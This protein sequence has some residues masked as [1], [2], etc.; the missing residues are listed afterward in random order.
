M[1]RLNILF[2]LSKILCNC[3]LILILIEKIYLVGIIFIPSSV[4]SDWMT[5]VSR[6]FLGSCFD[7]VIKQQRTRD[8]ADILSLTNSVRLVARQKEANECHSAQSRRSKRKRLRERSGLAVMRMDLL[9]G[10]NNVTQTPHSSM[11][12]NPEISL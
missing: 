11:T 5:Y 12:C 10:G 2:E 8:T 7:T 4:S 1:R 6:V 9:Y 3:Y